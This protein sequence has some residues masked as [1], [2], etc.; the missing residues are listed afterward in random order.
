MKE[1][2]L[3]QNHYDEQVLWGSVGHRSDHNLQSSA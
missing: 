2:Y 1:I 3:H